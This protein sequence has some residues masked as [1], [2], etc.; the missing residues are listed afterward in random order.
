MCRPRS[1]DS[2]RNSVNGTW[3]VPTTL[4]SVGHVFFVFPI[5]RRCILQALRGENQRVELVGSALVTPDPT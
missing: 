4:T 3:N 2:E 5:L 1:R